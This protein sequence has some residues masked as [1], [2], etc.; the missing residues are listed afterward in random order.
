M[1]AIEILGQP[2]ILGDLLGAG[3]MGRVYAVEHPSRSRVAVKLLHEV[4]AKDPVMAG[5][6]ADEARAARRVSHRNVV[7]VLDSGETPGG[8]PFIVMEH[9][10]GIPLGVLIQQE[11]PLPLGRIRSIAL[12]LLA[13][14]AAIH[15]AGLVHADVKS[16]NVLV[17][18]TAAG[19]RVTI[20]DF[21]LARSRGASATPAGDRQVSGTPEYMAPEQIRGKPLT[22]A[23]DLYGA[24][25][26]LYEMLTGTTPFGVGTTAMIF[27]RH[28]TE[29]AVPPSLRCP[30]RTIPAALEHA[31]LRALEKDPAARHFDASMFAAAVERAC[32][33]DCPDRGVAYVRAAFSTTAPTRDWVRA[34]ELAHPRRRFA[35]GTA[36]YDREPVQRSRDKLE[37][38]VAIRDPDAIVVAALSLVQ[39]LL[40]ERRMV[41]AARELEAAA[42]WLANEHDAP[43]ALWRLLL[44]LAALYDGLRDPVRAR[45]AALDAREAAGRAA[46]VAGI[47]RTDALLRRLV[48]PTAR[49]RSRQQVPGSGPRAIARERSRARS[50]AAATSR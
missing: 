26:I 49:R 20:I 12:Q 38:A 43:G 8:E 35:E 11:G 9:V 10:A 6:I 28:L 23:A 47:E 7:R 13:G 32:P 34:H 40:D 14:L 4:L 27:E 44:T 30:D 41:A 36:P 3:G 31:I 45:R 46:S 17:E 25:V 37:E 50:A 2:C 24:S 42:A 29:D 33:A 22:A 21:G 48:A 39:A 5:R 1:T 19:D 18:S 16:D 15:R